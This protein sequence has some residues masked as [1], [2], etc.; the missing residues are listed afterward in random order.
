M[1]GRISA[2]RAADFPPGGAPSEGPC[3]PKAL[4]EATR[5]QLSLCFSALSWMEARWH[6]LS[7]HFG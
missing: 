6:A 3:I 4:I 5:V 2:G 7:N 1:R